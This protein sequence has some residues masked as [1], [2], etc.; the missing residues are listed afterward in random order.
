MVG[1]WPA[2]PVAVI[3]WGQVPQYAGDSD[4]AK[5]ILEWQNMVRANRFHTVWY[6]AAR[7]LSPALRDRTLDGLDSN[8]WPAVISQSGFPNLL[9]RILDNPARVI[10]RGPQIAA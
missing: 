1:T 9:R 5:L 7:T 4:P 3:A 2:G 6:E 10:M 8:C